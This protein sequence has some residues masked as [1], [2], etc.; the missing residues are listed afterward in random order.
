MMEGW[1][2]DTP[3]TDFFASKEAPKMQKCARYG[4][5]GDSAWNKHCG[6][7]RWGHLYVPE[8]NGIANGS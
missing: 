1:G 7:E 6:A 3:S 4:H 8:P 5:K 2:T